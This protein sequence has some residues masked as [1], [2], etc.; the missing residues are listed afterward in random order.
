MRQADLE[1]TILDHL[2]TRGG[3]WVTSRELACEIGFP[4][5]AVARALIRLAERQVLES[6]TTTWVSNRSR[7]R[8]CL[9]YRRVAITAEFPAWLMPKAPVV[10]I[11]TGRVV[12]CGR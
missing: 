8:D 9:A 6:I 2:G 7:V 11:G 3:G 1:K 12:R 10:V 4:W 5:R